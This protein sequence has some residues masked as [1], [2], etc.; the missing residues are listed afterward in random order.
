M[1]RFGWVVGVAAL[2]AGIPL[3]GQGKEGGEHPQP[4][5]HEQLEKM[6]S[7]VGEWTGTEGVG[8]TKQTISINYRVTGGGSA[9]METL[10]AGT[11]HE[12]LTVYTVDQGTLVLTHY[13]AMGNQPHMKAEA[14]KD[15]KVIEFTC[16]GKPGNCASEADQHM[17]AG[18]LTFVDAD[19]LQTAW[20][21]FKD[22]KPAM[23]VKF[24]LTRKK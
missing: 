22:G 14:Q 16:D 10:F 5:K 6:K 1:K 8:D 9:V 12:M 17:H 13:C 2:A 21:A 4:P 11:D 15:P 24:D 18:K 3:W 23:E 20:A 19:H 7:L